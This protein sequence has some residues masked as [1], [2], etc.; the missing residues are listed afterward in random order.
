MDFN[1]HINPSRT[2]T[3]EQHAVNLELPERL[4][5]VALGTRIA[6]S[7]LAGLFKHPLRSAVKL[8]TGGYLLQRGVTGY[9][10]VYAKIG[11]T[12]TEPVNVNIRYTFTV[13]RKR[14]DVYQF[15]RSLENLPL[16]MSH[17][18]NIT[19]LDSTHSHWEAK[20]PGVPVNINWD[21]QI[22]KDEPGYLIGWHS[23][24]GSTIDNAGKV[25]FAD[26]E[27][28]E[29]TIVKVVISYLP[30]AGGLGTGVAKLLNP[31]FESVVREDILSFKEYIENLYEADSEPIPDLV[32]ITVEEN[33]EV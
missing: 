15:W 33:N 18:E 7:G 24:P 12:S 29:G 3:F 25:E 31:L 30:P 14:E 6:F 10:Q 20:I 27:G 5:S 1:L 17:L 8:F 2:T 16:F 9:C 32:V 19:V 22:V 11:K 21:A 26:A 28:A 23:M 4:A 13:N